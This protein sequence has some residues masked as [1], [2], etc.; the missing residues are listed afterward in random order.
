[1]HVGIDETWGRGRP[2]RVDHQIETFRLEIRSR[3]DRIDPAPAYGDRI[4]VRAGTPQV[5]RRDG[6]EIENER[7]HRRTP[8]MSGLGGDLWPCGAGEIMT[9]SA[10]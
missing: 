8:S 6:A 5:S 7:V 3:T 1:M 4:A 10:C 2:V 9:H